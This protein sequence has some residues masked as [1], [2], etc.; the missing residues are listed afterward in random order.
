M[1]LTII[2]LLLTIAGTVVSAIASSRNKEKDRQRTEDNI[3]KRLR[4]GK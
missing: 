1:T 4:S 3:L 2:G